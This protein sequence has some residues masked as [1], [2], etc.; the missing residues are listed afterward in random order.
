MIPARLGYDDRGGRGSF[1]RWCSFELL[2]VGP[3]K[4]EL[5]FHLSICWWKHQQMCSTLFA[6]KYGQLKV[7]FRYLKVSLY[8]RCTFPFY[9]NPAGNFYSRVEFSCSCFMADL[10]SHF[11]GK[12]Q[13]KWKWKKAWIQKSIYTEHF[14]SLYYK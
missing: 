7:I 3:V 13:K 2:A 6:F 10:F 8:W 5:L 4:G 1:L 11:S 12:F 14:L 9:K